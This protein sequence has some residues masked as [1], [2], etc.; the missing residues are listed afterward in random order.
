VGTD[1]KIEIK[2]TQDNTITAVFEPILQ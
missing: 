2:I 1:K